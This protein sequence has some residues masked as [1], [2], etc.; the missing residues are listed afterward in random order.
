MHLRT[1][2][3]YTPIYSAEKNTILLTNPAMV[4]HTGLEA[5][6]VDQLRVDRVLLVPPQ[7][8]LNLDIDRLI[9]R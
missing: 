4:G 7:R 5:V 1:T 9:D 2:P 8:D 6:D 3:P